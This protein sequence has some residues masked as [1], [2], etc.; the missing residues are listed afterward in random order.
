V[1]CGAVWGGA[2]RCGGVGRLPKKGNLISRRD[3]RLTD[4][5]PGSGGSMELE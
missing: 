4:A 1:H 3:L 5:D 2:G